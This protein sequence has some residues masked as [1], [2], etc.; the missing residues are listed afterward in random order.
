MGIAKALGIVKG[1]GNN[2]GSPREAITRQ[3]MM[4]MAA[5]ALRLDSKLDEGTIENLEAIYDKDDIADYAILDIASLV[6]SGIIPE[7]EGNTIRPAQQATRAE[8]A[9]LIYRIYSK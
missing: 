6:K 2:M 4:V 1:T 3:E 8:A 9:K 7:Q 5:R